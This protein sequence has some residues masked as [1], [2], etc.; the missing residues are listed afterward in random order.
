MT[1]VTVPDNDEKK[2]S[3]GALSRRSMLLTGTS[4]L[5]A[6][7]LAAAGEVSQAHAQPA[8]PPR[9]AAATGRKPNILV[10]FGD[11]I[12][13]WNV[14][15][16]N[17][18]MMGYRT[19]NIDRIA[20][21]GAIFTDHYAQQS[22]TAGRAAFITGQSL[23]PHRPAQGRPARR[24]GRALREGPDARRAAQ[25]AGLRH[26]PVRQ[27]PSRRPQ[28]VPADRA[29][30]RRV[31]R[32]PLPPQRRGGAGEPRLS[33]EPGVPRQ[34]R[35]A[36]RAEMQGDRPRRSDRGSA[37]RPGRQADHRGH[38]PADAEAHGDGGRGVPRRSLDFIDRQ[39]KAGKPFFCWFNSTRMHIYTH[40]KPEFEGQDRPRPRTPTAWSSSTAW[41]ASC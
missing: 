12:G 24:Q 21:E 36:R 19:P 38:R 5:A 28:R 20:K 17:R 2:Q 6:T 16:Y 25:A 41:S 3:R 23:L 8:P 34:V 9:P 40:L 29:R 18:G 26:R 4:A 14:S 1:T 39:H 37:L 22:C 13:Y 7:G 15:A 27:E 30:L 10:I 32:Q 11:D 35:P 33:E 31:L